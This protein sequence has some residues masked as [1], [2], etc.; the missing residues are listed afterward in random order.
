MNH[1]ILIQVI[2]ENCTLKPLTYLGTG[3]SPSLPG[4]MPVLDIGVKA[5]L[6]RGAEAN[7]SSS[8]CPLFFSEVRAKV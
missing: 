6:V 5:H 7:N 3:R 8:C 2:F 1:V 4:W